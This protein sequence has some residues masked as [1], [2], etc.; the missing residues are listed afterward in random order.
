MTLFLL[1]KIGI[2]A[3]DDK[4]LTLRTLEDMNIG[5][6]QVIVNDLHSQIESIFKLC[7]YFFK[8]RMK[9]SLSSLL[10]SFY[11]KFVVKH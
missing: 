2:N 7:F 5:Q 9:S 11:F 10:F 3:N 8:N 6:L 4:P 1:M